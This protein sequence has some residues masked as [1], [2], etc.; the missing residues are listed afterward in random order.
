LLGKG[1]FLQQPVASPGA[2]AGSTGSSAPPS[3]TRLPWPR[4]WN[5]MV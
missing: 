3:S 5:A 2:C 4:C 1:S